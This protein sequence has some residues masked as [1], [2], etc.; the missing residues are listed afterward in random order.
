MTRSLGLA[1]LTAVGCIDGAGESTGACPVAVD[2]AETIDLTTFAPVSR[3]LERRCGS[4]DCHGDL[5]RPL[6]IHGSSGLRYVAIHD[7]DESG[8]AKLSS[9]AFRYVDPDAAR[10][11]G[12]FPGAGGLPTTAEELEQNVRSIC[13]LEPERM[14]EV[15][16]GRAAPEQLLLLSKPLQLERHKGSKVFERGSRDHACIASWLRSRLPDHE[17][18]ARSCFEALEIP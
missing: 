11:A 5:A 13:G 3:L 1:L 16:F 8:H 6:R 2:T 9:E 10:I 17:L 15:V 18:D 7:L 12:A 4:L 14:R